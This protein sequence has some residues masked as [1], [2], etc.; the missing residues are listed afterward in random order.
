MAD[1][2]KISKAGEGAW[3]KVLDAPKLRSSS[4]QHK[5]KEMD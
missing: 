2:V 5:R 3:R 4:E 1:E